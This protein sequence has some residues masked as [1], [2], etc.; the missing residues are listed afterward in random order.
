MVLAKLEIENVKDEEERKRT[1]KTLADD[2]NSFITKPKVEK[3]KEEK[4]DKAKDEK[5]EG[6]KDKK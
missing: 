1:E 4:T 3:V 2:D 5:K 6:K